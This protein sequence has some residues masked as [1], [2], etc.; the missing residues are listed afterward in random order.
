MD[1]PFPFGFPPATAF[2]LTLYV[3]TLVIHV[4]FM[5]Y[6]LAGSTYLAWFTL[7]HRRDGALELDHP[8]AGPLRDWLPFMLSAAITAGIAPLLFL[9]ILYQR[10]FYT[11][12]LLLFNRWMAILPVLI[13]GFY[14]L[15]LLKSRLVAHAL[16]YW[17]VLVG[18]GV[19]SCFAFVAFSWTEN[20]LLSLNESVWPEQYVSG[21]WF[22]RT[23]ELPP[24]LAVWFA[25]AWPV[26]ATLVAWQNW[27]PARY[28]KMAPATVSRLCS[29]V[30]LGGL[31]VALL[32]AI[33]YVLALEPTLRWQLIGP[34]GRWYLATALVGLALQ[35]SGWLTIR[36]RL[37]L[38]TSQLSLVSGGAL[39]MILGTSGLRE[40]RRL[41]ALDDSGLHDW[42]T[43]AAKVGGL[44][45]FLAFA[46]INAALV[47]WCL[48]TV[49]QGLRAAARDQQ[50]SS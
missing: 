18:C 31:A 39:L 33:W 8:L 40:I 23:A 48:L 4:V 13:I 36:R 7:T 38:P 6:V 49:R 27:H 2:Y 12:N 22:Y 16:A 19:F 26:M 46:A 47:A 43:D 29:Q 3:A 24:R 5:N 34:A 25:G 42:H 17:R 21:R 32:C 37:A 9:Q 20:H 41:A 50:T 35:T 15:Y 44:S 14:L 28:G 11:A 45:V 30:A 10:A 1:A